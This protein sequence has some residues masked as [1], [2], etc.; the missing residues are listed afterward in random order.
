MNVAT[1]AGKLLWRGLETLPQLFSNRSKGG[2]PIQKYD[3]Y[4]TAVVNGDSY[5]AG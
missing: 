5:V 2:E 4:R 1:K 3:D